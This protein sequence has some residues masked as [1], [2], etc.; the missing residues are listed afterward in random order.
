MQNNLES[1]AVL[2]LCFSYNHLDSEK[3]FIIKTYNTEKK[4]ENLIKGKSEAGEG[5]VAINP[6]LL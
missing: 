5:E 1:G 2:F 6:I 4:V 3:L